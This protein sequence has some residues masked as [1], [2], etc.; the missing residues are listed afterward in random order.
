[1]NPTE[2]ILQ[3]QVEMQAREIAELRTLV[4]SLRERLDKWAM[5]QR[6][7]YTQLVG[8]S[9]NWLDTPWNKS[10]LAQRRRDAKLP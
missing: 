5:E 6:S 7:A 8:S 4:L 3:Q 2:L 1:M 9:E 10:L